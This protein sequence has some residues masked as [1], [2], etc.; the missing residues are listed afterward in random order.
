[1]E[2]KSNRTAGK[3]DVIEKAKELVVY[4]IQITNNEKYFPKRY[5]FSV[6]NQLQQ[7]SLSIV[8]DLVMAMEIYPKQGE[9]IFQKELEE[10]LLCQK[11]ARASCRSLMTLMEISAGIF[12]I[13]I[14]KLEYWTRIAKDVR[15]MTSAWIKADLKRFGIE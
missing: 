11:R 6:V 12:D 3:Y 5:R 15:N 4:T 10:R 13:R 9:K 1:M 8:D 14:N 2:Y 7:K